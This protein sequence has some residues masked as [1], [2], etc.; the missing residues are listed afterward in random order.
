MKTPKIL[1]YLLLSFVGLTTMVAC[2]SDE[3]GD[4]TGGGTVS[5]SLHLK[6]KTPD[7]ERTIN[8]EQLDL[9]PM[10]PADGVYAVSATS[11]STNETFYFSYPQDSSDMNQV[12]NYKKYGIVSY[13]DN[14]QPFQFSQKL[15]D[16]QG[17]TDRLISLAD[18]SSTYYNEVEKIE[19]VG[20]EANYSIFKVKCKYNMRTYLLSNE[21]TIKDVSG[22]FHFKIRTTRN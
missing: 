4:D 15:P 9:M 18:N 8:C 1:S 5:N 22:T 7:W 21:A 16:N 12:S 3:E 14:D 6:F 17:S 20:H 13:G 11:A 10:N 19:Y 2:S